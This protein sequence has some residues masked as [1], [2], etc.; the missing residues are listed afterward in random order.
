MMD[1]SIITIHLIHV[2]FAKFQLTLKC[3]GHRGCL[4]DKASDVLD[5]C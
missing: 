3:V 4:K 1:T 5:F 2:I